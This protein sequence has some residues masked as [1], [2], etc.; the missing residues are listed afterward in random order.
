MNLL[1]GAQALGYGAGW[2]TGWAAYS[3]AVLTALG[4]KDGE[5]IAGFVFIGT[6]GQPPEERMRP[7]LED[8]MVEWQ[9]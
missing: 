9:G 4:G 8:V 6:R 5:R 7:E 3:D 1:L 2:V